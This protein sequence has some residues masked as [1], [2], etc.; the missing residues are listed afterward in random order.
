MTE[1]PRLLNGH[2][3]LD[4]LATKLDL[5]KKLLN[6]YLLKWVKNL[7]GFINLFQKLYHK[8][9]LNFFIMCN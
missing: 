9:N 2:N 4:D 7:F 3:S 8:M 6:N 5:D 1:L